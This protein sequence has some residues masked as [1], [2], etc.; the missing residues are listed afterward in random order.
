MEG[1]CSPG[2]AV[3]V[4]QAV[5][6]ADQKMQQLVPRKLLAGHILGTAEV[7]GVQSAD[8]SLLK[9]QNKECIYYLCLLIKIFQRNSLYC[10][11]PKMMRNPK[12]LYNK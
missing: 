8:Y 7:A 4:E 12:Y 11:G 1:N 10:Y 2:T 6:E 9:R 5:V 3:A